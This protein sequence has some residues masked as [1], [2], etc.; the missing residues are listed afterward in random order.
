MQ[1]CRTAGME[2]LRTAVFKSAG[3]QESKNAGLQECKNAGW[4]YEYAKMNAG[5]YTDRNADMKE[6]LATIVQDL[7]NV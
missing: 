5:R 6:W 1:E 7:E 3:L 4:R 2:E